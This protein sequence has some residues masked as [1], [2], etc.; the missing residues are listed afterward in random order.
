VGESRVPGD[1]IDLSAPIAQALGNGTAEVVFFAV[2]SGQGRLLV[3]QLRARGLDRLPMLATSHI[4]G[5][6][7]NRPLDRD[8]NDVEFCDAIDEFGRVRRLLTWMRFV[9]GMPRAAD[10]ALS[11]EPGL[12]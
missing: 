2:R 4:Y 10:G 5:G 12:R 1:A 8:L 11:A 9:D 7:V 3:P 6:S